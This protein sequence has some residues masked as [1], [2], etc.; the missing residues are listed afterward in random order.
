[1]RECLNDE[2]DREARLSVLAAVEVLVEGAGAE[3]LVLVFS[4]RA[5]VLGENE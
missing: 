5:E 4:I 2:C 3:D 1:M